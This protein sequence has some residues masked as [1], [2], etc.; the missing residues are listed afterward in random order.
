MLALIPVG[1]GMTINASKTKVMPSLVDPVN[2]QP[3]TLA[4]RAR[5]C[6]GGSPYRNY[7][8]CICVSQAVTTGVMRDIHGYERVHLS[9]HCPDDPPLW[10]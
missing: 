2:W 1:V 5:C 6:C 8:V 10:M 7:K 3:L 4:V 9:S